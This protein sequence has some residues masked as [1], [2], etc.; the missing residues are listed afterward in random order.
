[1]S[2]RRRIVVSGVLT[3]CV[4]SAGVLATLH[5]WEPGDCPS[6]LASL[7]LAVAYPFYDPPSTPPLVSVGLRSWTVTHR[8]PEEMIGGAP[9]V[10]IDKRTC[11][12]VHSYM[13]Q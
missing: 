9:V 2:S 4:V 3:G 5:H 13:T 10:V 7:H 8:L 12:V 1:M 11:A 6:S